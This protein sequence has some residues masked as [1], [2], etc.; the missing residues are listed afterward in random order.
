MLTDTEAANHLGV[1]VH[2]VRA[3]RARKQGPRYHKIGHLV[4]YFVED[5]D[6]WVAGRAKDPQEKAAV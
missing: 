3:W 6:G 4:R 1:S 5:L 2:T